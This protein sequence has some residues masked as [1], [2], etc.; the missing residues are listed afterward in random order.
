[1]SS[2]KWP[3]ILLK[4]Q[5]S[6]LENI[7]SANALALGI[8]QQKKIEEWGLPVFP[9]AACVCLQP[10]KPELFYQRTLHE[11]KICEMCPFLKP[12]SGAF[13]DTVYI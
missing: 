8:R 11:T 1:M 12:A 7:L 2:W 9:W 4:V 3:S 6:L 10:A 5:I 13:R